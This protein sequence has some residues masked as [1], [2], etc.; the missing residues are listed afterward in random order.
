[1]PSPGTGWQYEASIGFARG[2]RRHPPRSPRA[3]PLSLT[4]GSPTYCCSYRHP[5]PPALHIDTF[6]T[7][8][9]WLVKSPFDQL[10]SEFGKKGVMVRVEHC[11]V[12]PPPITVCNP[13]AEA[14]RGPSTNTRVRDS[15]KPSQNG[16]NTRGSLVLPE[17]HLSS[18]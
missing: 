13:F 11:P 5:L 4:L 1:M 8:F 17:L 18:S 12:R 16:K 2:R 6:H 14:P 15:I 7:P 3:P 9:L 10:S